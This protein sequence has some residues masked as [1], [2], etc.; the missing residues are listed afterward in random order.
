M[1]QGEPSKTAEWVARQRA[2]H[3]LRDNSPGESSTRSIGSS[4]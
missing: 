1:N 2:V 4:G 3:Q